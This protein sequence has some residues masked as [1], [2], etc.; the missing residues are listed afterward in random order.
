MGSRDSRYMSRWNARFVRDQTSAPDPA[1]RS[2]AVAIS[3]N[4]LMSRRETRSV[5]C[6]AKLGSMSR[7]RL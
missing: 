4:R 5:T 3:S 2:I 6:S 7:R 1:A